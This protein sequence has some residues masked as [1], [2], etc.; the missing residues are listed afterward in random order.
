MDVKLLSIGSSKSVIHLHGQVW[1]RPYYRLRKYILVSGRNSHPKLSSSKTKP[2]F[3]KGK[4]E[5]VIDSIEKTVSVSIGDA[6]HGSIHVDES[7]I[8]KHG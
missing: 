4:D 7:G 6:E 3:R 1:N 5:P 2:N 8:P